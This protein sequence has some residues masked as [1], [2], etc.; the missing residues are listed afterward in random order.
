MPSFRHLT[1][2]ATGKQQE[3][4]N[5]KNEFCSPDWAKAPISERSVARIGRVDRGK[6]QAYAQASA[7]FRPLCV[8]R[9]RFDLIRFNFFVPARRTVALR[10]SP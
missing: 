6:F 9:K 1:A 2:S 10:V 4:L 8:A 7:S 3:R 5:F